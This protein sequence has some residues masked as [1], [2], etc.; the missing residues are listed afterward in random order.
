MDAILERD[1]KPQ[2]IWEY[3]SVVGGCMICRTKRYNEV[4]VMRS[5]DGFEVRLCRGCV[6]DAKEEL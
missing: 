3:A 4:L 6:C 2:M 1:D 5:E